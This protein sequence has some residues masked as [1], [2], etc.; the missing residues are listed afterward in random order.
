MHKLIIFGGTT[1]GRKICQWCTNHTIDFLYCTATDLGTEQFDPHRVRV[2]RMD[3]DEMIEFLKEE[4]PELVIDG[5]HPYADKVSAHIASACASRGICRIPVERKASDISGC[6]IFSTEDRLIAW[7]NQRRGIIF[8]ATGVK[9]AALFTRLSDFRERVWFRLLPTLEG[10][11]TCLDAGYP[12]EH[13]VLMWGPFSADLNKAL[14]AQAGASILV[15]KDS[16]QEGGFPQKKQAA[17]ERGMHIALLQRPVQ[18]HGLSWDAVL[19][20][21]EKRLGFQG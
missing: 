19:L 6:A 10:L 20:E 9:E 17:L 2:G 11:K 8:C 21:I 18:T 13:L 1:E 15:T 5:T 14:F 3:F 16:G 12:R 7:L 4:A